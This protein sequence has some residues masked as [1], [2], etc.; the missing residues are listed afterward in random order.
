MIEFTE[1]NVGE[2]VEQAG[3]NIRSR[4]ETVGQKVDEGI[5]EA[6]KTGT[7]LSE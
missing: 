4:R 5:L 2:K 7:N 6:R 3:E 1:E